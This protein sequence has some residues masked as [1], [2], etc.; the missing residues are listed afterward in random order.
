MMK[1]T[2]PALWRVALGGTLLLGHAAWGSGPVQALCHAAGG[3][4]FCGG[5]PVFPQQKAIRPCFR[6]RAAAS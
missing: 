5:T 1:Q 6:T 2:L 3:I 4:R